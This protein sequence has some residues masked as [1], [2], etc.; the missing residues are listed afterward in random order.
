MLTQNLTPTDPPSKRQPLRKRV[1]IG[2]QDSQVK[3]TLQFPDHRGHGFFPFF[4]RASFGKCEI[5]LLAYDL[6]KK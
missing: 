6:L 4:E 2:A 3:T 1:L 5:K